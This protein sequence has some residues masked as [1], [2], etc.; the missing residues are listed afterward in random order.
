MLPFKGFISIFVLSILTACSYNSKEIKED[1]YPDLNLPGLIPEVFAPGIVS[2]DDRYEFGLA[3]SPTFDEIIFT[4][5]DPG[6]GLLR[7]KKSEGIWQSPRPLDLVGDSSYAQ[8]AFYTTD[9]RNLYF[10]AFDSTQA[11]KIWKS[12]RKDNEW[13]YGKILDSP[14]NTSTEKH[15]FYP[16]FDN[17]GTLYFTDVMKRSIY[18]SELTDSGY[19]SIETTGLEMSIHPFI[20]PDGSFLLFDSSA[21]PTNYGKKDIYVVFRQENGEWSEPRNLGPEVNTEYSETC[22]SLSPD[23]K[24]LF[25]GRYNDVNEKSNI[26]WVSAEVIWQN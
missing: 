19:A 5:S 26:Y 18:K 1:L 24:F 9:G 13:G 14:V 22:P 21:W 3:V 2:L 23:G 20:S 12:T 6:N 8:E 25:F 17:E 10:C 4:V 11:M 16:T 7:M 15:V